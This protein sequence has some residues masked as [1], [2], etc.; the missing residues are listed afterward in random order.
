MQSCCPEWGPHRI[1][2]LKAPDRGIRQSCFLDVVPGPG[3][4][5][6]LGEEML[7]GVFEHDGNR[8][9]KHTGG[10]ALLASYPAFDTLLWN[11]KPRT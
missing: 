3:R 6:V 11:A 9:G 10:N 2:K 4:L 8:Q 1:E 7:A 5:L